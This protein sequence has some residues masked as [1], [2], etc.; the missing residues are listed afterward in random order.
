[1]ACGDADEERDAPG[2]EER[3]AHSTAIFTFWQHGRALSRDRRTDVSARRKPQGRLSSRARR[4]FALEQMQSPRNS[5]NQTSG[6]LTS[7]SNIV[8]EASNAE[9]AAAASRSIIGPAVVHSAVDTARRK[10]DRSKI[11]PSGEYSV[12]DAT[13]VARAVFATVIQTSLLPRTS[14][15]RSC[16]IGLESDPHVP[17]VAAPP[18]CSIRSPEGRPPDNGKYAIPPFRRADR[19]G[20]ASRPTLPSRS[21][22]IRLNHP[23][24]PAANSHD[25]VRAAPLQR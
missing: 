6:A 5:L 9:H 16:S 4:S 21:L 20:G 10:S 13:E 22:L 14:G 2:W 12:G 8:R 7:R 24:L 25:R 11:V 15:I 19:V 3:R 1:M 18:A 17:L 23:R